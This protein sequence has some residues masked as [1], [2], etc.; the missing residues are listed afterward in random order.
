VSAPQNRPRR[1][2]A[3]LQCHTNFSLLRG[4]SHPEELAERA[5][6]LRYQA[7]AI[8]DR[9]TLAG[10]V[11]MHCAAKNHRIKLIVGVELIPQDAPPILLYAADRAQ[12][13]AEIVVPAL[14]RGAVVLCDRYLDATLA[15]Q[16]HGRGLG[17]E[18]VLELHRRPP[19]DL[20]PLR[21][22]LLDLDPTE[23][24]RRARHRD[25]TSGA[26][27]TEGRFEA[28]PTEFHDRVRAGYLVLAAAEP[29][30][31]RVVDASGDADAVAERVAGAVVDVLPELGRE[32]G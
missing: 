26:A 16:G 3:E 2:Y 5:A 18:R 7:I 23:G 4:A 20:R 12:H 8:T 10:A 13:L 17:V 6:E 24:L 32:D 30:R 22:V 9:H 15:Y 29:E 14:D 1:G 19:L 21:T 31:Y 11:R 25:R 27:A 28:E